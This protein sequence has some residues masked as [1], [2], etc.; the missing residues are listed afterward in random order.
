MQNFASGEAKFCINLET[1]NAHHSN[2][3]GSARRWRAIFGGP[4]KISSHKL[5]RAKTGQRM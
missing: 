1:A 4:P 5:S 3:T 2:R